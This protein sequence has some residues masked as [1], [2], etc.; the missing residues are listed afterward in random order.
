VSSNE[1][2]EIRAEIKRLR[3]E[4][5]ELS[6]LRDHAEIHKLTARYT[7]LYYMLRNEEC[8]LLFAQKRDDVSI[9]IFDSGVFVGLDQVKSVYK[10]MTQN[11]TR[12]GWLQQHLAVNPII[13]ISKDRQRA[14]GLW[15]S[16]GIVSRFR[17]D[18]L[19]AY[20]NW[21]KYDMEYVREDGEWKFLSITARLQFQSPYHKGWVKEPV[22][23][24]STYAGMKPD[25]PTTYH[26]PYNPY[27]VNRFEPSPPEPYDD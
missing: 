14:K 2:E 7:H 13:E 24:S 19:T 22:A 20:W 26:M 5:D 11:T 12:P 25:L 3:A 17:K 9:E 27:R 4:V 16:P 6:V 23:S 1:L 8:F 18:K 15:H 21:A 10:A